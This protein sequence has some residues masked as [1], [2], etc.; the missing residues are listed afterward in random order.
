MRLGLMVNQNRI[1]W[2]RMVRRKYHVTIGRFDTR[3]DQGCSQERQGDASAGSPEFPGR[4]GRE[5]VTSDR[6]Q[7]KEVRPPIYS[8]VTVAFSFV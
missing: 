3:R 2:K 5:V 8:N 7:G 4:H 1:E 6:H